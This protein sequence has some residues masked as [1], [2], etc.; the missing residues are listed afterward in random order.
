MHCIV[1]YHS[2]SAIE[3]LSIILV[4]LS[5]TS[6]LLISLSSHS[7]QFAYLSILRTI[8]AVIAGVLSTASNTA[9][10]LYITC[11]IITCF[12]ITCFIITWFCGRLAPSWLGCTTEG[13]TEKCGPVLGFLRTSQPPTAWGTVLIRALGDT[14][15]SS[16]SL[17]AGPIACRSPY[18][19]KCIHATA[20]LLLNRFFGMEV[21]LLPF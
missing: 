13:P 16:H 5:S 10:A 20:F 7:F 8:D 21:I 12:I 3:F 11:F 9:V 14:R 6:C 19:N 17:F 2:I 1:R 18:R 15:G 4:V